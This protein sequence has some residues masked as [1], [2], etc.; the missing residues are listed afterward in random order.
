M[1]SERKIS[2]N[3]ANSRASTGAKTRD[4]KHRSA[5][6]AL[7]HTLSLPVHSDPKLS[8][9]VETLAGQI[10][11]SGSKPGV[12][13]LARHIAEAQIDLCRARHARHQFL[14]RLLQDPHLA[15]SAHANPELPMLSSVLRTGAA[16]TP[17][18]ELGN[19]KASEGPHKFAVILSQIKKIL[20]INRYER[21]ALSRRKFAI[22]AF[23]KRS[24]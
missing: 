13:H 9:A 24:D 20:A 16:D 19:N 22:R 8:E 4:G 15:S 14:S 5:R 21:R 2:A 10:A 12:E 7:R 18:V 23:Y 6:N 11:G 17:F 3:R 1:T